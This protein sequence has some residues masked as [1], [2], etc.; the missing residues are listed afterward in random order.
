LRFDPATTA[1]LAD[2][3]RLA[4]GD[5]LTLELVGGGTKRSI[6]RPV[7]AGAT[8]D[9]S[10]F[11]G[12]SSYEPAELVIGAGTGTKLKEIEA[13]LDES[14]QHLAFEPPDYG[15]LLGS[16]G[17]QTIGGIVVANLAGPRR[18]AAGAVRD[19]L[20]GFVGV[21]GR[22]EAFKSGGAVVKNVT[23]YDLSK[24]LA[25]SW[26]TLAALT[27]VNLKVLPRPAATIT[28]VIEGQDPIAAG[29]TMRMALASPFEVSAAAWLPE[30]PVTL[31]RLE[32]PL[33]SVKARQASLAARLSAC[34]PLSWRETE[35]SKLLWRRIRDVEVLAAPADSVVW[36]IS[37][38]PSA[39][40]AIIQAFAG[41]PCFM[42]WAGGLIWLALP[43]ADDG[44]AADLRALVAPSGGHATLIRA[45]EELRRRIAVLQPLAPPL[46][47]LT[48]RVKQSFDPL[49]LFNPGRLYDG[50]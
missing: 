41:S 6:G 19:H 39:G 48:R 15:S 50:I 9:L 47:A 4:A 22:A 23:G 21:N 34:G 27:A 44:D 17:G 29:R 5:G 3:V 42:D 43:P 26:G 28:C 8:L 12:I 49:G 16:E 46:E 40:P 10:G 2:C 20:L 11:A 30:G 25:G 35:E 37:V 1:D 33:P 24:L 14:G 7:D 36:K 13:A 45:P 18:L 31:L 38:P 32:G